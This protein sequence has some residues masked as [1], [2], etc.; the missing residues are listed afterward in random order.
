MKKPINFVKNFLN[1]LHNWDSFDNFLQEEYFEQIKYAYKFFDNEE[2][3]KETFLRCK[4]EMIY[5]FGN[6]IMFIYFSKIME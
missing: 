3:I 5:V 2:D 4:N 6:E 1:T